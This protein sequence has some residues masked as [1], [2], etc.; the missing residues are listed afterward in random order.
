MKKEL[1]RFVNESITEIKG[2]NVT[3]AYVKSKDNPA[4]IAMRG[5]TVEN[6]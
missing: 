5:E 3:L 6:L 4:D 1:K 2:N